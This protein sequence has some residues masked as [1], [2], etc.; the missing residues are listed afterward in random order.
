MK[1]IID[2]RTLILRGICILQTRVICN[3]LDS[4]AYSECQR[5]LFSQSFPM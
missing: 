5:K 2:E 3:L 4:A 1:I